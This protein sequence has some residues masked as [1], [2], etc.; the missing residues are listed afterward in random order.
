[1]SMRDLEV[2]HSKVK[3][4]L[5]YP[6]SKWKISN[7]IIQHFPYNYQNMTYLEPFFGSGAVFFNKDRSRIETINDLDSNV[8]NL[9]KVVRDRPY[10]LAE[11]IRMTPWSREEY[12]SS[13]YENETDDEIEKARKYIVRMWQAIGAKTSDRTGWR[14]NISAENRTIQG[15]NSVLPNSITEVCERLKHEGSNVVQ[16]ENQDVFKLIERYDRTDVLIYLDPPYMLRTR[17]KRIYKHEFSDDDH[18]RMLEFCI[19]SKAKIIISGYDDA[20]YRSYLYDWY[21]DKK[22]A[23]CES[24]QKRTEIIWMNYEPQG[25]IKL[26]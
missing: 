6:G 19:H 17:N 22:V 1:M 23:D 18:I 9:F 3:S 10:E 5:K 26:F 13:Y 14:N 11:S 25:Q 12:I 21:L 16:I 7:W 4:I 20:L 24:G 2:W 15:F 8:Y